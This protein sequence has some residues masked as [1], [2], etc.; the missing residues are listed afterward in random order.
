MAH[1]DSCDHR[2]HTIVQCLDAYGEVEPE[3]FFQYLQFLSDF[4]RTLLMHAHS[5]K[6][7]S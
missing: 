3:K 7:R 1:M 5:R 6:T 2:P 4:G